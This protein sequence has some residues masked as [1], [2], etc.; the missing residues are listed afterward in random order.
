MRKQQSGF[1]MIELIMV[2][3]ILGILAA[4]A[5]PRFANMGGDARSASVQGL[6]GAMRSA[7]A[8]AHSAQLV[9]NLSADTPV[10]L[11]GQNVTMVDGYP[12][13]NAAGIGAATQIDGFTPSGGGANAG[14]VIT[15]TPTG[16]TGSNCSVIYTAADSTATDAAQQVSQVIATITGCNG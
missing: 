7:A 2:I 14:N 4:V 6:A 11:E 8:I 13:A 3:V 5:L 15:Y 9:G 1:T 10:A 12:T 16:F